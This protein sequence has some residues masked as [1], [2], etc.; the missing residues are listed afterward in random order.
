VNYDFQG[1]TKES[2]IWTFYFW[3]IVTKDAAGNTSEFCV[4]QFNILD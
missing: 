3:N 2:A 4:Y 1:E